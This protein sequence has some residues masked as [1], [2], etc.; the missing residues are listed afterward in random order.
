MRKTVD[1]TITPE[2]CPSEQGRDYHKTYRLTEMSAWKAEEWANRA[3]LALFPRLAQ[4]V[5]PETAEALRENPSMIVL[6]RVGLLLGALSFPELKDLARELMECV[7]IVMD[8]GPRR[9]GL[10]FGA[11]DPYGVDIEE[12]ETIRYLRQEVLNLHSG[13]TRAAALFNLVAAGSQMSPLSDP[14][15]S[16]SGSLS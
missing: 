7:Q 3:T 4:E 15:T 8:T 9:M 10:G 13:F 11:D 2:N 5:P 1:V 14:Q 12:V 6:Q 16:P